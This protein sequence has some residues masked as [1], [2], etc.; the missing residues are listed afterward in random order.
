MFQTENNV[1]FFCARI[2]NFCSA[3]TGS[4]RPGFPPCSSGL[5]LGEGVRGVRQGGQPLGQRAGCCR[6]QAPLQPQHGPAAPPGEC[7]GIPG[8]AGLDAAPGTL[9][10]LGRVPKLPL[11]GRCA[12]WSSSPQVD[13]ELRFK[14]SPRNAPRSEQ[15]G[16]NPNLDRDWHTSYLFPLFQLP[17]PREAK[18][19]DGGTPGEACTA[20]PGEEMSVWIFFF[21]IFKW[22]TGKYIS[23]S[24]LSRIYRAV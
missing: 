2:S 23:G 4:S 17:G 1:R 5:R 14:Y 13:Y 24:K 20:P 6:L 18:F 15:T 3:S 16:L 10:L 8:T 21:S 7:C 19:A 9:L 22:V 11:C 12:T